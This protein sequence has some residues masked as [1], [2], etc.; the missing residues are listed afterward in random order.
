MATEEFDYESALIACAGGDKLALHGIYSRE[1]RRMLGVALRIV[2]NRQLAED[3]IHDAFINI[4][5]KAGSFDGARGS[6]LSWMYRIVR[7]L[8]LN[9]VRDGRHEVAVEEELLEPDEND[10]AW[11]MAEQM[12]DGFELREDLGRLH[13]CLTQLDA[14]KRNS[15]LYA[16]IDGCSHSEIAERLHAPLGT[17]KAWIKRGIRSLR[18]C[19]A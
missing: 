16:Y 6:A 14:P 18:E 2:R 15:I 7:N 5:T 17:V 8:A 13:E 1:C 10:A 3:V 9:K 4:W 11:G 12:A 19:M